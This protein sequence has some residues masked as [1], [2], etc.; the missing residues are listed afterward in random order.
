[1]KEC[2]YHFAYPAGLLPSNAWNKM[3]NNLDN[4]FGD[5]ASVDE[6]FSISIKISK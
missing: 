4:H 1:M 2:S 3:M 6:N 5:N